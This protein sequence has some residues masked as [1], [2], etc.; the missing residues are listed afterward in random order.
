MPS[1]FIVKTF[2]W[3]RAALVLLVGT[4]LFV[5]QTA[6][7]ATA[8]PREVLAFY[9]P[10]Y[11]SIEKRGHLVHWGKVNVAKHTIS[12]CA[13]YPAKGP[14]DSCDPALIDEQIDLAKSNGI[15]GFIASWWGPKKYE[16]N[17]LRVLLECARK[18][19]FKVSVYWEKPVGKGNEKIDNAISDLVY[20]LAQYGTNT[21]FLKVDG[22]PVIFV[23]ERVMTELPQTAW[24][25][26]LSRTKAKAGDFLLIADRY[27]ESYTRYFH[28]LHRYN[29]SWAL[30]GKTPVELRAWAAKY[31]GDGVKLA[32]KHGR[33]SCVTVMPGY[34]DTKV[35]KPGRNA[36][37]QDGQAYSVLWEEAIKSRPDWVLIN[38]WNEWHEGSEIESSIEYGEKYIN[39]TRQ[40]SPRFIGKPLLNPSTPASN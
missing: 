30:K 39:L 17:A 8:A 11:G 14:Y 16:D 6:R 20:L 29:I 24:P 10:W 22:K 36:D 4:I 7:A 12:D 1:K 21:A 25:T 40:Y 34:D 38:S 37:R 32:R 9:Y 35:N 2:A 5:G 13:H 18:K 33:I 15:T 28:G 19:D 31:Y 3:Y 23:Y 26:I 27:E